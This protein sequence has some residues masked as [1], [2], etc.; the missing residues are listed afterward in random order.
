[1]FAPDRLDS[2]CS[3]ALLSKCSEKLSILAAPATVERS[4]DLT[5]TAFDGLIELLRASTPYIVSMCA[6]LDLLVAADADFGRRN[7]AGGSPELASLRQRQKPARQS[8]RRPE[9]RSRPASHSQRR[10]PAEKAGNRASGFRQGDRCRAERYNSVRRQ[11][12]RH[13]GQ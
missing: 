1:V 4:Y 2:T 10:R 5:E 7:R 6:C 11:I 3:T 9:K 12:V 8:A 13:G